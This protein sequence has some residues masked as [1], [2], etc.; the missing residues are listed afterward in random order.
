MKDMNK[1]EEGLKN[2]YESYSIPTDNIDLKRMLKVIR[3]AMKDGGYE[4][5]VRVV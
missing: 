4:L 3:K 5:M 2:Y 1:E